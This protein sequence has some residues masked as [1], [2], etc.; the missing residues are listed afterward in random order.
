MLS[1]GW[2]CLSLGVSR[3]KKCKWFPGPNFELGLKWMGCYT[4]SF[5]D[6]LVVRQAQ[7][8]QTED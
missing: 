3:L 2:V 5:V 7:V 8:H 1:L 4:I 6:E